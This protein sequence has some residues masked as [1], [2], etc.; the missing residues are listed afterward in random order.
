MKRPTWLV[1]GGAGYIGSHVVRSLLDS[2]LHAVVLDNL[3]TGHAEFIPQGTPFVYGSVGDRDKVREVLEKFGVEGVIHLAGHKYAGESVRRPLFTYEQNVV[4]TL[5]LLQTMESLGVTLLVFSSSA[6][7]YGTPTTPAPVEED[8]P[9]RPESPYGESKLIGEWMIRNQKRLRH[10]S[11]RY[12]NVIGSAYPGLYDS[13]PHNL[14]PRVLSALGRGESP[15]I[16]GDDYDTPDGSCVR[17]YV[18]VGDVAEAHARAALALREGRPLAPAYNLGSG[19]GVSVKQ[20]LKE[21][22]KATHSPLVPIIAE[23]RPGDPAFI[24]ASDNL[25]ARDLSWPRTHDVR[26]MV[27]SAVAAHPATP[28]LFP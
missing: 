15:R 5:T 3:S 13:S 16:F 17:D 10:T 14:L 19:D 20:L 21:V 24:V 9:L 18:Y 1:T 22:L 28:T 8:S 27:S 26:V 11:L 7:V 25:A 2:G 6:A 23:R 4:G 12:F